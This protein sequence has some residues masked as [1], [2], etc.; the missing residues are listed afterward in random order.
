MGGGWAASTES[1]GVRVRG[2]VGTVGK[3]GE[4]REGSGR[5]LYSVCKL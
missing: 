1:W 4:K 3:V 2:R 5:C